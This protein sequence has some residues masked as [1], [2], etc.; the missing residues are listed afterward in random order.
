MKMT[1][2]DVTTL[3]GSAWLRGKVAMVTGAAR[4]VGRAVAAAFA[5]EDADLVCTN[6]CTPVEPPSG[7][8]PANADDLKAMERRVEASVRHCL[9]I[10]LDQRSLPALRAVAEE[11]Q[12]VFGGMDILFA[13]AGIQSF[14]PLLE[15]E[16]HPFAPAH[17]AVTIDWTHRL[18]PLAAAT[19]SDALAA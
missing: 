11:A 10:V 13:N 12:R 5:R 19:D 9:S 15:M 1:T 16:N 18:A 17:I 4:G 2:K 8:E 3:N 6:I 14:H 7:V